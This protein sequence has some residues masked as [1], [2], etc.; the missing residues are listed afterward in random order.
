MTALVLMRQN[1]MSSFAEYAVN[2]E[3]DRLDELSGTIAARYQGRP[4]WDFL[5][6]DANER[7]QWIAHELARLQRQRELGVAAPGTA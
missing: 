5:P 6:R 1:V 7:T 2:I 3:L 4:N